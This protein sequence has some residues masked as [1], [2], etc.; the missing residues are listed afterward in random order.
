M[1]SCP[2][3]SAPA[4]LSCWKV[5]TAAVSRGKGLRTDEMGFRAEESA[6]MV[7]RLEHG[8]GGG[9]KILKHKTGNGMQ[10]SD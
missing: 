10:G 1:R 8:N 9:L 3:G 2:F 6:E 7:S 5:P 4:D